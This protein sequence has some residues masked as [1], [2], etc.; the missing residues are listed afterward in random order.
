[1]NP[2]ALAIA[3]RMIREFVHD[4]LRQAWNTAIW[5]AMPGGGGSC[6]RLNVKQRNPMAK[7][8]RD[9]HHR[10][11][12]AGLYQPRPVHLIRENWAYAPDALIGHKHLMHWRTRNEAELY[13]AVG[14]ESCRRHVRH[15]A[16]HAALILVHMLPY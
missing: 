2:D 4:G 9:T 8:Q 13:L 15:G 12:A 11:R 5:P 10:Q 16:L 14:R 3:V 1:V 6:W 7:A